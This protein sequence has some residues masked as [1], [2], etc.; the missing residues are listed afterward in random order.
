MSNCGST[1]AWVISPEE[2]EG[3]KAIEAPASIS[4]EMS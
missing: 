3:N 4:L 1:A 2:A